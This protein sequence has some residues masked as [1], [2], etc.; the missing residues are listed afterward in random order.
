M[1]EDN[2]HNLGRI[3]LGNRKILDDAI[4]NCSRMLESSD[5]SENEIGSDGEHEK[6]GDDGNVSNNSAQ[7]AKKRR[8]D[9]HPLNGDLLDDRNGAIEHSRLRDQPPTGTPS[10][11]DQSQRRNVQGKS[12]CTIQLAC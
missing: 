7:L 3:S 1:R 2:L 11:K 8:F 5:E 4:S 12:L 9:E 6:N 10:S